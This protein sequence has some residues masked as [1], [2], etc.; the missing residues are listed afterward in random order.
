M[1]S[2]HRHPRTRGLTGPH[3]STNQEPHL[4]GCGRP[5][6][7]RRWHAGRVCRRV[8]AAAA[9]RAGGRPVRRPRL[10]LN[11]PGHLRTSYASPSSVWQLLKA[12]EWSPQRPARH[13]VEQN[14]PAGGSIPARPPPEA[15]ANQQPNRQPTHPSPARP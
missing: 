6:G 1:E 3:P 8:G 5:A 2:L 10:S 15:K 11:K 4:N 12:H 13:A 9:S 7:S 14:P